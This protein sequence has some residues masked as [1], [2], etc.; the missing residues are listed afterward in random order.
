MM[1]ARKVRE[2]GNLL[3]ESVTGNCRN[4][5]VKLPEALRRRDGK[6]LYLVMLSFKGLVT[7]VNPALI[8]IRHRVSTGRLENAKRARIASS[9]I[10]YP[11]ARL[12]LVLRQRSLNQLRM[13]RSLRNPRNLK[14]HRK[15]KAV[16]QVGRQRL[17]W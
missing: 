9:L 8:G 17:E 11:M 16:P 1:K 5:L 14:S 12:H 13:S 2:K 6:I 3:E 15:R 4:H 10:G 7:K